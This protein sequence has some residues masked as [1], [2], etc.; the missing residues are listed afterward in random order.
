MRR[1]AAFVVVA[2]LVLLTGCATTGAGGPKTAVQKADP[3]ES[4]NRKVYAFND[5]VDEAV[6]KPA[7]ITYTKIVPQPIRR[8]VSN[9]FGNVSDVWSALNNFAQGKFANGLQ[10]VIRVG[11]NTLFGLGGFLD[12]ASEFGADRQGEDLGQTLGRWG[13][14]PG[15][16]VVWP[17]LGPSTLRD[18]LALP[19]DMQVSP[20][21]GVKNEIGKSAVSGLQLVNQRANLLG[22]SGLLNDIALDKYV[23]VRDAYLQRRRSL[24]FDGDPPEVKDPDDD[25]PAPAKAASAPEPAASA[26]AAAASAASQANK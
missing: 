6:V 11:T 1:L 14:A 13:M 19:L 2:W 3:W 5:S 24:V 18:S 20:A 7:A 25:V 12:V 26:A 22:A 4:W 23:F 15:P 16:Y 17:V 8:G 10:D 21:L 9:F